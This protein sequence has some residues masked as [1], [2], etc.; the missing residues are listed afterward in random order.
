VTEIQ[1]HLRDEQKQYLAGKQG[2]RGQA[3]TTSSLLIY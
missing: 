2:Y 3:L 1:T